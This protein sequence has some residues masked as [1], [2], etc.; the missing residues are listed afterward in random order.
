MYD[1][2]KNPPNTKGELREWLSSWLVDTSNENIIIDVNNNKFIQ[3]K[4]FRRA[5]H[6]HGVFR[7]L[8]TNDYVWW[9]V[10]SDENIDFNSFPSTRYS[11]YDDLLENVINDYYKNWNLTG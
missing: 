7:N 11:S 10:P 3:E 8:E 4:G 9:V 2:Y 5:F 1:F 6:Q